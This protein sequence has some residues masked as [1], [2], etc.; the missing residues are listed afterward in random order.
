MRARVPCPIVIVI[1][2]RIAALTGAYARI[3][4]EA[5]FATNVRKKSD[6][7]QPPSDPRR[8]IAGEDWYRELERLAQRLE[9]GELTDDEFAR[10]KRRILKESRRQHTRTD[11]LEVIVASFMSG[12]DARAAYDHLHQVY[13]DVAAGIVDAAVLAREPS[14]V[15]RFLDYRRLTTSKGGRR[16]AVIGAIAEVIFPPS[17]VVGVD[18]GS[19]R[20][21]SAEDLRGLRLDEHGLRALGDNVTPGQWAIIA[22]VQ[23]QTAGELVR[24]VPGYSS[25]TMFALPPDIAS[26]VLA[27]PADDG[28]SNEA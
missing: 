23:G 27:E 15:V 26:A 6:V 13:Q 18:L 7:T 1:A 17:A 16:P 9:L 19:Q 3:D 8:D 2:A 20:G 10:E 22:L 12:A 21:T 4:P 5:R 11:S 25:C 28:G 14:G 24:H